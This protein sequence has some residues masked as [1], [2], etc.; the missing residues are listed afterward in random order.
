MPDLMIPL[1]GTLEVAWHFGGWGLAI[2]LGAL[3]VWELVASRR[4]AKAAQNL[5]DWS[6]R[7][8]SSNLTRRD[9]FSPAPEQAAKTN[10]DILGRITRP[11]V[12]RQ[13]F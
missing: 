11:A 5:Q 10:S 9:T 12:H 4:S 13:G 8:H 3:W 6:S 7:N 2:V 1:A